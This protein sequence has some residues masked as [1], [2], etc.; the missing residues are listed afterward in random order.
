MTLGIGLMMFP[1]LM[2]CIF[3]GFPVAFSLMGVALFF[4]YFR[5][6]DALVHQLVSK[7]D[8]VASYYVLAAV[9]LFV[10][11]GAMLERSGIAER[12]FEAIHLW[13]RRLP[14][15]L[16]VGTVILCVVFAAASGVV[17]ATESVV[18]L[19]AIPVMLRYAYDKGLIS[20]TICAGGSL[21]TIIPPSVVVVILGPVADVSVGDLFVGMLFPGLILAG[22]YVVY[23]LGRCLIRPQD[24]PSL[25]PDENEPSLLRK[26][27][28][29]ATALIPPLVLIFAVLG[30]IMLGWATPTEAAATGAIGTVIMT[31]I[32]RNFSFAIMQ[33]AFLKTL[34]ITAMILT[35]LLGGVMFAG[36]F[37]ALGGISAVQNLLEAAN[38][39]AWPTMLILMLIAFIAGFVLDLISIVLIIIPI[40]ITVLRAM[41][42]NDVWFCIMFL[43]VI[44]TSYLTPP[45]APAIFY[46][47]G[48][49]PPEIRLSDMYR[50]VVPFIA[51]E[52][53]CLGLVMVF[54]EIALWLPSVVFETPMKPA[55]PP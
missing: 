11:M 15:G 26:L 34:Q 48:I 25:P 30:T 28:I 41:G 19:L 21:G 24:G 46:L 16:A 23:I 27:Y 42:V 31:L 39:T 3:I 51:L 44:Q 2:V 32:Y 35:I 53:I 37:V 22:L 54:P 52:F 55:M 8:D 40:A 20:G 6:G 33:E 36:V 17:G 12:L 47:R 1:A 5:F 4:G 29:T 38:L 7:V 9:P 18:G 45:M 13:T 50:G 43:V 14:G 49:S 10:F